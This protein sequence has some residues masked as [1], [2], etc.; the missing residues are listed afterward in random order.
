MPE[1]PAHTV[2]L[3]RDLIYPSL[4]KVELHRHLEGSLRLPTM[5]EVAQV[6]AL[7]LRHPE[8]LHTLVQVNDDDPFT[9]KNFLSKFETLR[10]FYR[11]P[12]IISR[13]TYEA[14]ADAA[15]DHVRYLE[16][17]FTPV[18]LSMAQ[19]FLLSEVMDWVCEHARLA[20]LDYGLTTNLIVSV[21]RHESVKIAEQVVQLALDRRD[22]G[23]V[24]LDL[25]GTEAQF[26]AKPF[27]GLFREAQQAGLHITLHAGE[28]GGAD[29]VAQALV[30]FNAER[31]GH[32]VRILEDHSVIELARQRNTA[33]EVCIT[34][35]Y[36]SGVVPSIINHPA[37]RLLAEGLNVTLATDDPSISRITLSDEYRI[38]CEILGIPVDTLQEIVLA[39]ARAAFIS[40]RQR[41][42]L[43]ASLQREFAEAIAN[44]RPV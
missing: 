3:M 40:D 6:H 12:E 43:T 33:F 2:P 28:W 37:R 27:A 15:A 42:D 25:A 29:H 13:I 7:G 11:S 14:V 26:P 41:E 35:N 44:S 10:L 18:A 32:G 21:N 17:R 1:N 34:S 16:L 31:I 36:Q 23:I 9:F 30:D 20:S 38:A 19:G 5:I 4:P 22:R 24:G 39:A 8:Q